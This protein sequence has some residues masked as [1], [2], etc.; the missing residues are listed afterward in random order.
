MRRRRRRNTRSNPRP[1]RSPV[2]LC[3]NPFHMTCVV[4]C[5]GQHAHPQPLARVGQACAVG[6]AGMVH[7]EAAFGVPMGRQA[8]AAGR[9][10]GR[11]VVQCDG[12]AVTHFLRTRTIS[13]ARALSPA[14]LT[15]PHARPHRT[16]ITTLAH[17]PS[18][19]R[20]LRARTALHAF[21]CSSSLFCCVLIRSAVLLLTHDK[22]TSQPHQS[23]RSSS[24]KPST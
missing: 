6:S 15:A 18:C 23:R 11:A 4:N 16:T 22:P 2:L 9:G 24:T 8:G 20:T 1:P 21:L 19:T 12:G 3:K 17:P 10:R 13:A 14:A 7:G 5:Y